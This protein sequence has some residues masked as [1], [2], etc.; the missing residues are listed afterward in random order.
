MKRPVL[1]IGAGGH[2][3]VVA[4]AL[5][6]AE[7]EV[8]GFLDADER[9]RDAKLDGL[10]VIGGDDA[11]ERYTPHTVMLANGMGSTAS[12]TMRRDLYERLA[13]RGF[14]FET[15]RHPSAIVARS[16]V[17]CAGAQVMAGAVIQTGA[18]V[19]EDSI[20]NTGA[21]VDHDCKI[22]SHCHIAPGAV[23]SGN[24]TIGDGCHVGTGACVIQGTTIGAGA[25][26]A[27]GAV[28]VADVAAQTQVAGVPARIMKKRGS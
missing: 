12:M 26:I 3:R 6:A 25:M 22:G 23:L 4:D 21:V 7:H 14:T 24:V 16:A 19:G 15:V 28:V 11:L 17:L 13:A 10:P 1:V 20:I 5:L 9:K 8:L 27:A 2:G 18:V